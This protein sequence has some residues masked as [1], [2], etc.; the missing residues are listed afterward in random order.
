MKRSVCVF[1][2]FGCLLMAFIGCGEKPSKRN[3]FQKGFQEIEILHTKKQ[4]IYVGDFVDEYLRIPLELTQGSLIA[5]I[6]DIA[7]SK[8]AVYIMGIGADNPIMQFDHSGTFIR[9]IGRHGEGPGE[10][11]VVTSITYD[12]STKQLFVCAPFESKILVFDRDGDLIR[13]ITGLKGLPAGIFTTSGDYWL[14]EGS[15]LQPHGDG[16]VSKQL[17]KA[18]DADFQEV[19]EIQHNIFVR[20]GFQLVYRNLNFVFDYA[21]ETFLFI[22]TLMAEAFRRDTLFRISSHT[23]EPFAKFSFKEPVNEQAR[24]PEFAIRN[25]Q[26][27]GGFYIVTYKYKGD[28]FVFLYDR[29]SGESICSLGGFS[30]D[31]DPEKYL[32]LPKSNGYAYFLTQDIP[33]SGETEPNPTIHWVKWK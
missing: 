2:R 4:E 5:H 7:V 14:A 1:F 26:V 18:L 32:P 9:H 22:P 20:E 28:D 6:G 24:F 11:G 10:Y 13:E 19:A 15:L 21:D 29:A 27:S 3:E 25:I 8:D 16:Y 31:G 30:F 33:A 23:L 12:E 17:L